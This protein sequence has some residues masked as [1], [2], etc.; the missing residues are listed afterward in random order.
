[1]AALDGSL[2]AATSDNVLWRR[3]ADAVNIN[4]DRIGSA[5]DVRAMAALDGSLFAATSDNVLWRRTAS[6]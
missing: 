4:W 5:N 2:F 6:P 1:M 3:T